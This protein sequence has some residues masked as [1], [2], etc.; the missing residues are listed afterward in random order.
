VKKVE[1][2]DFPPGYELG[3]DFEIVVDWEDRIAGYS[4]D[5]KKIYYTAFDKMKELEEA[6]SSKSPEW[7][8][9]QDSKKKGQELYYD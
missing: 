4:D 1:Y 5:L 6:M 7:V 3:I 8:V 9:Q 2:E